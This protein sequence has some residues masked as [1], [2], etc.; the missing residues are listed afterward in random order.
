MLQKGIVIEKKSELE[1][2][3]EDIFDKKIFTLKIS[4]K[5]R[6]KYISLELEEEVTLFVHLIKQMNVD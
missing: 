3:I 5:Q 2:L 1:Y 6:M 4:G